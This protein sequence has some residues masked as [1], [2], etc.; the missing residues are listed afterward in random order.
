MPLEDDLGLAPG[1]LLC[2]F[3]LQQF[4]WFETADVIGR[5]TSTTCL[6]SQTS[7]YQVFAPYYHQSTLHRGARSLRAS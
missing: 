4:I 1:W 6:H 2:G 7:C 5:L 3:V